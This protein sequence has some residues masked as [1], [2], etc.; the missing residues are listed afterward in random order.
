[1][2]TLKT[3]FGGATQ[4]QVQT[5]KKMLRLSLLTTVEKWR[6]FKACSMKISLEHRHWN[7]LCRELDL[8][9]VCKKQVKLGQAGEA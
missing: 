2:L 9:Q 5:S 1:M 3:R 6:C 8:K 4:L 7:G